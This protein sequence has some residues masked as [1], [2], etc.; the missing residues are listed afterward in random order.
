VEVLHRILNFVWEKEEIPD[1]RK[2]GL[3]VKLARKGDLSL[4]G[5]WRGIMLL[6]I[7]NKVLTRVMNEGGC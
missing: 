3:L 7:P 5:N 2:R 4:C 1:D 6:S